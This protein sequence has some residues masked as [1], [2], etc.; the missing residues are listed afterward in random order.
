MLNTRINTFFFKIT[1]KHFTSFFYL[2]IV[3]NVYMLNYFGLML[4][5]IIFYDK[6]ID[7]SH[8]FM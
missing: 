6:K 4:N 1:K 3:L 7:K 2:L 8:I 5:V